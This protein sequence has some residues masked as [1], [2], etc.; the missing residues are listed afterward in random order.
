M[1][2]VTDTIDLSMM[3]E[4]GFLTVSMRIWELKECRPRMV[5]RA[6]QLIC[7]NPERVSEKVLDWALDVLDWRWKLRRPSH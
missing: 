1:E 2:L 6:A 7:E 4:A 3:K 5:E